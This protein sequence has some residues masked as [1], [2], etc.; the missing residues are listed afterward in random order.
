[1]T[2][3]F[4]FKVSLGLAFTLVALAVPASVQASANVIPNAG[5]ELSPSE[6]YARIVRPIFCAWELL[7]AP[8]AGMSQ[9]TDNPHSGSLS[10]YIGWAGE[11]GGEFGPWGATARTTAPAFCAAIGPGAHAASFW[12]RDA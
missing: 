5:F 10:L 6:C 7:P 12:F 4:L 3:S 8:G 1:M 2:P 9:D 11:T